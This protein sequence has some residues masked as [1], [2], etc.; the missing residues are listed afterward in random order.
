MILFKP[1]VS[2]DLD[3]IKIFILSKVKYKF[4]FEKRGT[5]LPQW[6]CH[7]VSPPAKFLYYCCS[8]LELWCCQNFILLN[9]MIF[10]KFINEENIHK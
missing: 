9:F 8:T 5:N 1:E 2:S 10:D 4:C 3:K 7:L 6:L